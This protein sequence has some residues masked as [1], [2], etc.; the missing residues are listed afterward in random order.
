MSPPLDPSVA[1]Q[2]KQKGCIPN[3]ALGHEGAGEVDA[4][5]AVA[6]TVGPAGAGDPG[7][8]DRGVAALCG[9]DGGGEVPHV[10]EDVRVDA[11][12]RPTD[13]RRR[14]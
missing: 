14:S 9:H 12:I 11:M 5:A 1:A 2:D 10:L 6:R 13:T 4:L 8:G 7:D 3:D